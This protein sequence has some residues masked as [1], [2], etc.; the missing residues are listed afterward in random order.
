MRS[1]AEDEDVDWLVA[2]VSAG[3]GHT[4]LF[5]LQATPRGGDDAG[6]GEE[7]KK[8]EKVHWRKKL[9]KKL[10]GSQE[11]RSKW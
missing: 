5:F 7:K 8:K 4:I 2:T 3:P 6:R 10:E 9:L 11:V 1:L